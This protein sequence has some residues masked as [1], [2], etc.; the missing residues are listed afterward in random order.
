M[1]PSEAMYAT[2]GV[3]ALMYAGVTELRY[4]EYS[5]VKLPPV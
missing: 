2:G 1:R 4:I 3:G 5:A